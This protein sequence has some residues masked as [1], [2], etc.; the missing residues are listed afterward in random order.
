MEQ[1]KV[2]NNRR[3]RVNK[4]TTIWLKDKYFYYPE[5]KYKWWPFWFKFLYTDSEYVMFDE[6]QDAWNFIDNVSKA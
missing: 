3:Y 5:V 4:K 6:E 2:I 1:E